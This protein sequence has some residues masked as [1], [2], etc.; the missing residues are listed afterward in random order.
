VLPS[1]PRRHASSQHRDW[2]AG[3]AVAELRRI[4]KAGGTLLASANSERGMAEVHGLF[5]AAV[6]DVL[7]RPVRAQPGNSFR[8]PSS[9][10][11]KFNEPTADLR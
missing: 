6:S 8:G 5:G 1:G 3:S 10:R 4:V 7:G 9:N 2:P 11:G